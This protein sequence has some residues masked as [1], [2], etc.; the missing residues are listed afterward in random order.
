MTYLDKILD[1]KRR[2]VAALKLRG[3]ARTFE[4]ERR[5]LPK[6]RDF[7]AAIKRDSERVRLIAELKKAS[8]SR[9]VIV[10][11]FDPIERAETYLE[12]GASAFSVLTDER[13]FQGKIAYL[14][15]VRSRYELPVLRK[16]FIIDETQL[17]ETRLIGADA[18]LL[19]VAA[20]DNAKL[21]DFL[22]LSKEIGLHALTEVHDEW[23]LERA[24]KCDAIIVGVNN[25]DLRDFS[26]SLETSLRVK[27][28]I[29]KEVIS[30]SESGI[31]TKADLAKIEAAGFDAVLIGEGLTR[32]SDLTNYWKQ[33][34]DVQ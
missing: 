12:L 22:Q 21:R 28:E 10:E 6:T 13:F 14:E 11:N 32:E 30:V 23:E 24:M 27:K 3:V 25:R 18:T 33:E 1:E 29:P 20:L 4:A 17:L 26:V 7:A 16:D 9:G 2:E 34:S 5:H 15:Q 19:I 8:P 31:Q